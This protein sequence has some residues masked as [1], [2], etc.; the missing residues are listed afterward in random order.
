MCNQCSVVSS[1]PARAAKL[2]AS[3]L[4]VDN[5]QIAVVLQAQERLPRIISQQGSATL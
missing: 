2:D 1:W 3:F 4:R 5:A